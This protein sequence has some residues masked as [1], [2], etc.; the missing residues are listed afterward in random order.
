MK[1]SETKGLNLQC[2][3]PPCMGGREVGRGCETRKSETKKSYVV[4]VVKAC[5]GYWSRSSNC[6]GYWGQRI[7]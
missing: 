7:S 2:F 4:G 3:S 5:L 6:H 1:G